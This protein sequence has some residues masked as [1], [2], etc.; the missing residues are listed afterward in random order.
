M[1][2]FNELKRLLRLA[3]PLLAAQLLST[4]TG[5]VDTIM[6]GHY[7]A[8]DLAAVAVGNSLWMPAYLLIAGMLIATTSMVARFYGAGDHKSIVT[9]T[10]QSIWVAL[11]IAVLISVL[12]ANSKPLLVLFGV[13][14][15]LLEITHGY[16]FAIAFA[17]PAAAIFN[18]L[19]GFTEGMGRTKPYMLSSLLAFVL[20]IPLNYGLIY[21][22][23]GLPELGGVGCGWATALSFWIQVL[24]L[25]WFTSRSSE[26][27]GVRLYKQWRLPDWLEM[28]KIAKL[29]LPISLA[30]F[31]EVSIF[32]FIALL[33]A[34]LGASIV[35]GHQVALT[36]SHM[37]F[38]LPLSFS[39]A[40]TIQVGHY[41]GAGQQKLANLVCRTGLI[42]VVGLSL[43]TMSSILIFRHDII[44]LFTDDLEVQ[45]IA[46]SL[47]VLMAVY[48]LP[49]HIQI[50][51]NAGLR[52]YHDTRV[53]MG[54]IVAS[55]W[56]V[57]LPLGFVLA[58]TDWLVPAIGAQGFWVALVVGLSLTCIL[59][60]RRLYVIASRPLV[61]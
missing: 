18:G 47:F 11:L 36:S 1:F 40:L 24:V 5:V 20:N 43:M 59:L 29:G 48:Q 4:G 44:G 3:A 55:Y 51:A 46:A 12:L 58:R 56:G 9:A 10:Q 30:V 32:S 45:V 2:S 13:D 50:A 17:M 27:A 31:A 22:A 23:W 21:G 8:D 52:A 26:Y 19:R 15:K 61:H 7:S 57:C 25:M 49:D 41:L 42:S 33:L 37:I 14:G 60:T 34:P 16:I 39:Q 54:F 35:A 38:M 53:P 6:A 28:R